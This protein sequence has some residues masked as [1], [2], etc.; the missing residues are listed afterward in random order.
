MQ[1]LKTLFWVV[2]AV[3]AAVFAYR[4]WEPVTLNLWGGLQADVKLPVL[5]I[6]AFLIGLLPGVLLHQ[7]TRWRLRRRLAEAERNLAELRPAETL[8]ATIEPP[9]PSPP[10][11]STIAP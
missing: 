10:P 11:A 6:A 8:A 9:A 2:I 3:V 1:F 4:N 7:A 5:V